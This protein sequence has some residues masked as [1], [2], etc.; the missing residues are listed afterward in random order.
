MRS[1]L[2]HQKS[3]RPRQQPLVFPSLQVE[4]HLGSDLGRNLEVH[5]QHNVQLSLQLRGRQAIRAMFD[6]FNTTGRPHI[7]DGFTI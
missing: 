7:A 4:V 3:C 2:S 6:Y 5:Y 1:K